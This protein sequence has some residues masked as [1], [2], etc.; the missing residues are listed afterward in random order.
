METNPFITVTGTVTSFNADER[1]FTICPN[2]YIVLSRTSLPFPIHAHFANSSSTKRWGSDGPK[3]FVG[4]TITFGGLLEKVVLERTKEK[5]L[6]YAQV[7]VHYITY[8]GAPPNLSTSPTRTCS[9]EYHCLI[10]KHSSLGTI[11]RI[12]KF[13]HRSSKTMELGIYPQVI[14]VTTAHSIFLLTNTRK[15]KAIRRH[16]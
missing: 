3:V 6:E 12:R 10:N 13:K 9:S 15:E 4:T 16:R 2:Q 14:T 11:I 7:E 1:T 8:F 5:R